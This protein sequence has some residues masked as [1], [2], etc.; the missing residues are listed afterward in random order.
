[1]DTHGH[2]SGFA[3]AMAGDVCRRLS[4]HGVIKLRTMK[5]AKVTHVGR[6]LRGQ[7]S[8]RRCTSPRGEPANAVE[9][10]AR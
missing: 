7:G 5:D 4:Q 2:L 10:A 3:G 8:M 1:M 9:Y 6:W